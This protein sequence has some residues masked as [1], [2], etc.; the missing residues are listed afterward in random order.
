MTIEIRI[1]NLIRGKSIAERTDWQLRSLKACDISHTFNI[2]G[3]SAE[4]MDI[5]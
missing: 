3:R 1:I 2:K 5:P 4:A